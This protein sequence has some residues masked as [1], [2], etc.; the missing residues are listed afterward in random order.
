MKAQSKPVLFGDS[1][2]KTLLADASAFFSKLRRAGFDKVA[3]KCSKAPAW[4]LREVCYDHLV[5]LIQIMEKMF[6][7]VAF[8]DLKY[9]LAYVY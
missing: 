2:F 5:S 9:L 6:D 8:G 7:R 3:E 4:A 1:V